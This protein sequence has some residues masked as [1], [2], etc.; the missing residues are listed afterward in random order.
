MYIDAPHADQA[1]LA[2]YAKWHTSREAA[3]GWGETE[4]TE[5]AYRST[6]AFPHPA[7]RELAFY[8]EDRLVGVSI[9]DETPRALSAVYFF[10]DPE[11]ARY[12][13]GTAN[14][15]ALIAHAQQTQ[16]Q[17]LYLGFHVKDCPSL[18]YKGN[19]NPR[20][21]LVNVPSPDE[22][23]RWISTGDSESAC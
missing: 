22:A 4:M 1:R 15:L 18:A 8:D 19:F 11:Y 6:F 5:R 10:Y 14:V 3:R 16:R 23:P 2:L 7:A 13:L 17:H 9:F 12:S 20:E 21:V